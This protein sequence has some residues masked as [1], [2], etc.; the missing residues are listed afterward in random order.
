MIYLDNAS[1]TKINDEVLTTYQTLLARY[2]A[3]PSGNHALARDVD[4]LQL[5]ARSEI[6]K[7]FNYQNGK[8]IFTSG[9]TEANNLAL[10]GLYLNYQNRGNEIIIGAFE[11][12]SI[13]KSAAY[14]AKHHGAIIKEININK[15]GSLD[16][17]SLKKA[18]SPSTVLISIMGVNNEVGSV[19]D[20][21]SIRK[22]LVDFPKVIFHSD[23]TQAVGKIT[24]DYSVFDAFTYS[25]HKIHGLKGSGALVLQE[26][27]MVSP[28]IHGGSQE[29]GARAGTSNAPTN[30][31][32]AKTTR[33]ALAN[34][35]VAF[36]H[37]LKLATTLLNYLE[38]YPNDFV[39]HSQLNNPFIVNFSVLQV[40]ASVLLNELENNDIFIGTTSSCSAKLDEPSQSVLALT[41]NNEYAS[42]ALRV[43]F[44]YDNTEDDVNA[45][46]SV[47]KK[48]IRG[49]N[50]GK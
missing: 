15:D 37:V 19:I 29:A 38:T 11:H 10:I 30:I 9:G 3:N 14:L 41:G 42:N 25:A 45:L 22:L 24:L 17:V 21:T 26:K 27:L 28:L 12:P 47:I 8:V 36:N 43:S 48:A 6:L 1:T 35:K 20:L 16:L 44:S 49:T 5:K 33:L 34:Q 23:L 13:K 31:V 50:Y 46:I 4:R 2:F 32:M 7:A 40:K 39:I 18:L